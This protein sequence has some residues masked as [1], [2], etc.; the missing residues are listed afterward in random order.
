[1]HRTHALLTL[2]SISILLCVR[3]A[4]AQQ[5]TTT[6]SVRITLLDGTTYTGVVV[7]E[8]EDAVRLRTTAGAEI[9]IPKAQIKA[10]QALTS[11]VAGGR[12]TRL[13][14]NRTRLL[15]A[16]TARPLKA[17]QGYFA[18]YE[19]FLPFVAVGVTDRISIGGGISIV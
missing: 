18:D 9:T 3:S 10:R 13:D 11:E 17:G 16:P 19:I 15:V 8:D 12:F 4:C 5:D 7:Q 14:P 2:F 6:A 1:M